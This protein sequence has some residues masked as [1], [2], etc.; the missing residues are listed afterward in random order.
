[1]DLA[2]RLKRYLTFSGKTLR[3]FEK[4]TG[5]PYRSL[6]SYVSGKS[7]PGADQLVLMVAAGIDVNWLL[8]GKFPSNPLHGLL[9]S[10]D[11]EDNRDLIAADATMAAAILYRINQITDEFIKY[12]ISKSGKAPSFERILSSHE[13]HLEIVVKMAAQT[14]GPIAEG[15]RHRMGE[16]TLLSIMTENMIELMEPHWDLFLLQDDLKGSKTGPAR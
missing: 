15:R 4:E 9:R 16:E 5:I 11:G 12:Y 13:K 14:M 2:S 6:Q 1:M 3:D 7:K 10:Q 8:T